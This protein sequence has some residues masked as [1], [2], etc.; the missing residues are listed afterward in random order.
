MMSPDE[1]QMAVFDAAAEVFSRYGF[2]R[3]AMND[4]ARAAGIS[5]PAL[6]LMFEN[7][8]D[9]FRQLAKSRQQNAIDEAA[10]VL[11][12]SA[13]LSKR[14]IDAILAYEKIYYEP[15]SQSPHGAELMDVNFSIAADEMKKGSEK[16][17][18]LLSD[19][20]ED[21]ISS[22]EVSFSETPMKPRAFVELLMSSIGGQ[23]KTATSNRDFRRKI[24][25]V[26]HIFMASIKQK[27]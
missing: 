15:V 16:L 4:I 6:Y 1:K 20:I 9:L 5:R 17:V 26:G 3:T 14:L 18:G 8:E 21:S 25:D 12:D 27:A 22:G 11:T 19:A 2:R 7:K 10:K 13:P 24:R 23:K